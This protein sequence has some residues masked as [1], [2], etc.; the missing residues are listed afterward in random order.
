MKRAIEDQENLFMKPATAKKIL[1]QDDRMVGIR[2]HLG[3]EIL[4]Q[5]LILLQDLSE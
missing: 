5:A 4:T 3:E 2:T 1:I